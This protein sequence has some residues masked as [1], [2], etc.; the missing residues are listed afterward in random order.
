M[1]IFSSEWSKR[2]CSVGSKHVSSSMASQPWLKILSVMSCDYAKMQ[3]IQCQT[4]HCGELYAKVLSYLA[5]H[6]EKTEKD[7]AR[8]SEL[9]NFE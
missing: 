1:Y 5:R 2:I 9:G 7:A 8:T 6:A 3:T 4:I